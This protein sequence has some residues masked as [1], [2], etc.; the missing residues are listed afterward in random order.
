MRIVRLILPPLLVGA[1]IGAI[2]GWIITN[3]FIYPIIFACTLGPA[4]LVI[5]FLGMRSRGMT[6]VRSGGLAAGRVESLQR[7]GAASGGVQPVDVRLSVFSQDDSPYQTTMRASV[8]D[9]GLRA[10]SPGAFISVQR[11]GPLSRP[12]V[13]YAPDAPPEWMEQLAKL[14]AE[15]GT[16][17]AASD[18]KPWETAT[19]TTPGTTKPGTPKRRSA[20][21]LGLAVAALA[22]ALVLIPAYSSIARGV[23]N[24]VQGRWDGSNMV[25]GL[26]QQ[27]SVDQ[28]IAA[29]GTAEFTNL[30]F[31]P[32]YILGDAI[33]GSGEDRTDEV[34]WRYGRAWVDGPSFI[35]PASEDLRRQLFDASALDISMVAQ[36]AR[37]GVERSGIENPESVYA[38]VR[39]DSETGDPAITVTI[40]G[41]YESAYL[42]YT[43]DGELVDASGPAFD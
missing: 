30:A 19:T 1:V 24:I 7:V 13:S 3:D 18:V 23:N 26:Y 5:V 25:T 4:I 8:D 39:V 12:D 9:A 38:F 17:P 11:L 20:G 43:F 36:V 42:D 10:M 29:A 21:W 16:L 27:E 41:P 2:L 32:D 22:I 40:S 33:S 28:M 34:Q 37:D 31:Y 6:G 35:Q 15:A 14:R